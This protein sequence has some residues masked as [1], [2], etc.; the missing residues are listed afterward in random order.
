[1]VRL[2]RMRILFNWKWINFNIIMECVYLTRFLPIVHFI[3]TVPIIMVLIMYILPLTIIMINAFKIQLF[4]AKNYLL[5]RHMQLM[6]CIM[7]L[8]TVRRSV[9]AITIFAHLIFKI[10]VLHLMLFINNNLMEKNIQKIRGSWKYGFTKPRIQ[11]SP[12]YLNP[13]QSEGE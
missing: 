7:V 11:M 13:L 6:A 9:S 4:D 10:D 2:L 5:L 1:M 8:Q 3:L 12:Y